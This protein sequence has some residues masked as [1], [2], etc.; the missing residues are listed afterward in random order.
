MTLFQ[1]QI[2]GIVWR[3]EIDVPDTFEHPYLDCQNEKRVRLPSGSV[4]PVHQHAN[5]LWWFT[6]E[7]GADEFGGYVTRE[8][9]EDA[10]KRYAE[11]L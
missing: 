4:D 7:T 9:C 3:S 8:E 1:A 2:R 10:C 5:G 6:D 11:S